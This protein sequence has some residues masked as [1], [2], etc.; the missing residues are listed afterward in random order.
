M[1][2]LQRRV[3]SVRIDE[4]ANLSRRDSPHL[5]FRQMGFGQPV[6]SFDPQ[7]SR[8][9]AGGVRAAAGPARGRSEPCRGCLELLGEVA[10]A[11]RTTVLV[12]GELPAG[13]VAAQRTTIVGTRDGAEVM[14]FTASWYCT[15]DIEPAWDLRADGLAGEGAG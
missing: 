14:R 6:D 9:P 5:L 2:S 11:R 3:E 4:F 1:L 10:A 13:S 15:T 7:R 12:A 8:V